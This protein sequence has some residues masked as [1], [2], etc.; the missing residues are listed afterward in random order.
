MVGCRIGVG[1]NA[2]NLREAWLRQVRSLPVGLSLVCFSREV[3]LHAPPLLA[4]SALQ[5]SVILSA[6][7]TAF[8]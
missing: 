5:K 2:C 6:L 1:G 8:S 3:P 4:W 7:L